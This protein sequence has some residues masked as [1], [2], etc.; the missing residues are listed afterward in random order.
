MT[1]NNKAEPVNDNDSEDVS[2]KVLVLQAKGLWKYLISKWLIIL[3]AGL[4]GG[5]WGLAYALLTKPI[6]TAELSFALQDEKSGGGL[7]GALG[8]ASQFGFDL[9]GTAA[10]D[11]FSGDNL[12]ELMKSRLMIQNTLLTPIVVNGKRQTLAEWY[13][14][15][16]KLREGWKGR[17]GLENLHFLPDADP[18][19][20][21]LK[22]D[23][24][25]GVFQ[26]GLIKNSLSVDKLD[27]KLSIVYIKVRSTNELFAKYFVE[28]LEK[29][30]SVFYKKT[31][32]EKSLK[33]VNILTHQRDSVRRAL[34]AAISGVAVS[35]DSNPNPNPTL[36]TLRVPSTRMQVDIKANTAILEEL[37]KNLEISKMSLLQQTPLIEVIDRPILPLEKERVSK[38]KAIVVGGLLAGFLAVIMLLAIRQYKSLDI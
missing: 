29:E 37:V 25:L 19:K 24:I 10:G 34:N 5:A 8:L 6:Y 18:L 16:N 13:I 30:V 27:K 20:F 28:I 32:T 21:T 17:P 31:K 4:L 7:S 26:K 1:P 15:F 38:L 22:Q 23:S 12:L 36:S 3:I 11:E 2:L 9:G 14:T 33:N 35:T